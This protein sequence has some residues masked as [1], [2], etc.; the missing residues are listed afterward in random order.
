MAALHT[1]RIVAFMPGQSP[2]EVNIPIFIIS[3]PKYI[4]VKIKK[5]RSIIEFFKKNNS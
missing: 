4:A 1:P 2:P 5:N 3:P